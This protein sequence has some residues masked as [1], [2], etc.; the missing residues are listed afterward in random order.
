MARIAAVVTNP[1]APDPR[2]LREARWLVDAGHEVDVH[3]FDRQEEHEPREVVDGVRLIRHRVGVTP[4]GGTVATARGIGKFRKA[5]QRA[6]TDVDLVHCHDADTLAVGIGSGTP[7]LFD[8]HDLHHTWV[9]MQNPGSWLRRRVSAAQ[10][11]KMLSQA[12]AAAAVITSSTGFQTWLKERGIVATVVENR[13]LRQEPLPAPERLTVG[14]LGVIREARSFELLKQ[15]LDLMQPRPQVLIAGDGIAAAAVSDLLPQAEMPGPFTE[16]ELPGL[17]ARISVM[18]ALYPPERGNILQGALPAKM[19]EA[20]A[21]GR[22]TVVNSGCH[23]GEVCESEQLGRAVPWGDAQ[24]LAA[25]LTE[26]H[27]STVELQHDAE[28]ERTRF[29]EVVNRLL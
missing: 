18:Y 17:M 3:A 24:A 12:G 19:F 2:V 1:C 4:F 15:A 29:L 25:A 16:S 26:I 20:A 13:P 22:P 8:M 10:Q 11:R 23:M 28:R 14:Y 27:G 21:F 9:R 5:A 7:T 6:I